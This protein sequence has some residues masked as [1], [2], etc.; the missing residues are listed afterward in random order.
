VKLNSDQDSYTNSLA[1]ITLIGACI[2]GGFEVFFTLYH[3]FS[4]ANWLLVAVITFALVV[5]LIGLYFVLRLRKR[6]IAAHFVSAS[7][8][9]SLTGTSLF[10]GGIQSSS[11]VWLLLV[12]LVSALMA[13]RKSGLVWGGVSAAAALAIYGLNIWAGI[14]LS[15]Q[16]PTALNLLVDL[17]LGVSG[18]TLATVINESIKERIIR[19]LDLTQAILEEQANLDALTCA[20]NRRYL[21]SYIQ[22]L[23]TQKEKTNAEIALL[24]M[25]IDYFKDFNDAHGHP[26]GDQILS[27]EFIAVLPYTNAKKAAR[28]AEDLRAVIEKTALETVFGDYPVTIS[29]GV[30]AG[31]IKE[32]ASVEA[33]IE[34]ADQA[35]YKAKQGGRNQVAF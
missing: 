15:V 2:G 9:L 29:I 16:Q 31:H 22:G 30:T 7:L 5:D 25:D 27:D 3:L 6:V 35:L 26:A 34:S 4:R 11:L 1:Q 20:Y 19:R 14:D 10:S 21:Y 24:M 23:F 17:V 13:G 12:P 32:Y 8:F 28:L 33:L 18:V